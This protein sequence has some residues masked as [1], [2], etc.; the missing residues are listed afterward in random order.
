MHHEE[1]HP[2]T[3]SRKI[4]KCHF[5]DCAELRS[6]LLVVFGRFVADALEVSLYL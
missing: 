2:G 1:L 5:L 3:E 4:R 6:H